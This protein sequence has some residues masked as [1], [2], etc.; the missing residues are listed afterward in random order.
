MTGAYAAAGL[1]AVIVA[2]VLGGPVRDIQTG[3]ALRALLVAVALVLV[4]LL[5]SR[6][7]PLLHLCG[8]ALAAYMANP[9]RGTV[10]PSWR[11]SGSTPASRR[12]CST[13]WPG[14]RWSV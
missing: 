12:S 9:P 1:V 7:R 2:G 13:A 10:G 14:W 11:R 4:T 5:S 3:L 6:H 8:I